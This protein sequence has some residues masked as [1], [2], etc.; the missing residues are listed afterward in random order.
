M[1]FGVDF[2]LCY[3]DFTT[4][5]VFKVAIDFK[6]DLIG[7]MHYLVAL[8]TLTNTKNIK[9]QKRINIETATNPSNNI[10]NDKFGDIMRI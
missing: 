3:L 6:G 4:I 8:E 2:A 7:F 10:T 9:T 1:D 5:Q